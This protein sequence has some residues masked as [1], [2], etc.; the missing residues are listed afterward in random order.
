M[1]GETVYLFACL[2][3]VVP[4][5][6]DPEAKAQLGCMPR[7]GLTT[8]VPGFSPN[9]ITNDNKHAW[10]TA[11]EAKL[12]EDPWAAHIHISDFG[13]CLKHATWCVSAPSLSLLENSQQAHHDTGWF[14]RKVVS[15]RRGCLGSI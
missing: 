8:K 6:V 11:I 4:F 12:R 15:G 5:L 13:A 2:Q 14:R 10:A 3:E 1:Q 7:S 9:C